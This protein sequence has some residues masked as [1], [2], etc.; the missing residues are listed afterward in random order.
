MGTDGQDGEDRRRLPVVG[1]GLAR[2]DLAP[3]AGYL[4]D[5]PDPLPGDVDPSERYEGPVPVFQW[6][7]DPTDP[8][9]ESGEA[10]VVDG[11]WEYDIW[12]QRH[13]AGLVYG[14]IQALHDD[15]AHGPERRHPLGRNVVVNMVWDE[16][17]RGVVA[18]YGTARDFRPFVGAFCKGLEIE[19]GDTGKERA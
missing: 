19:P 10:H 12:W 5:G 13:P 15:P 1:P 3:E 9:L 14:S 16:R 6:E 8:S 18:I 2:A 4:E 7:I 11:G 17:R